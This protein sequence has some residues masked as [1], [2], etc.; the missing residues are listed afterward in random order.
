M[1]SNFKHVSSL[2]PIVF[3][4]LNQINLKYQ[5]Q[6]LDPKHFMKDLQLLFKICKILETF[7]LNDL[8]M[9]LTKDIGGAEI[10]LQSMVTYKNY[11]ANKIILNL[12]EKQF[13]ILLSTCLRNQETGLE[14]ISQPSF[15]PIILAN[16]KDNVEKIDQ[17][18][19]AIMVEGS[20]QILR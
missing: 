8:N 5:S 7:C 20:I 15:L 6:N 14:L 13:V 2:I 18:H 17:E 3:Q 19:S 10:V 4:Q 11:I 9:V 16:I 12:L 1:F